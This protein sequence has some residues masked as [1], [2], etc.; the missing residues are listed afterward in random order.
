MA[1][2]SGL[3][4]GLDSLFLSTEQQI[5]DAAVS[6]I[7]LSDIDVDPHQPRKTFS[8]CELRELSV[9]IAKVNSVL[10]ITVPNEDIIRIIAIVVC[11]Q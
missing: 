5:S 1:K 9:S 10:G 6:T 4:R 7:R 2:K 3:G 8:E 11:H